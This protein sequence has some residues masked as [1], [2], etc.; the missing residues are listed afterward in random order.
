MEFEVLASGASW[1]HLLLMEY[2]VSSHVRYS[3]KTNDLVEE[4]VSRA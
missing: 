2:A 3:D 4:L 1:G